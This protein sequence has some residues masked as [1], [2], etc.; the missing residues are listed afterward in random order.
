MPANADSTHSR[1]RA[2]AQF[3]RLLVQNL[4]R[5]EGVLRLLRDGES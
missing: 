5:H 2:D 3:L 4:A 1:Y